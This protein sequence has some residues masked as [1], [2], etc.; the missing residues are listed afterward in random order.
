MMMEMRSKWIIRWADCPWSLLLKK[1]E[2]MEYYYYDPHFY[3]SSIRCCLKV[4]NYV[5]LT[6]TECGNYYFACPNDC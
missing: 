6:N 5:E 2:R 1:T 3:G 4:Y